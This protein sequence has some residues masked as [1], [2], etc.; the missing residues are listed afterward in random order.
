MI[1]YILVSDRH[2]QL[3]GYTTTHRTLVVRSI[4]KDSLFGQPNIELV[5][6]NVVASIIHSDYHG[7]RVRSASAAERN[8]AGTLLNLESSTMESREVLAL[9]SES[10]LDFVVCGGSKVVEDDNVGHSS[11]LRFSTIDEG[12]VDERRNR[13]R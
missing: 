10:F 7:L 12:G 1:E 3:W 8:K 11:S 13:A 9:E 5:C 2:F 4:L 6:V